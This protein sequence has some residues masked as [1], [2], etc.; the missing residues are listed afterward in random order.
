MSDAPPPPP[1][2][3]PPRRKFAFKTPT[4]PVDNPPASTPS[5][6]GPTDVREHFR[7]AEAIRVAAAKNP[8][9]SRENEVHGILRDNLARADAAGLNDVTPVEKRPNRR[10]RDYLI[11][12][13]AFN[14]PVITL[15]LIFRQSPVVWVCALAAFV[16]FNLRLAWILF[17]VGDKY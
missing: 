11:V 6:H 15:G 14:V 2:S 16:L 8:A 1:D 9:P 10:L 4:F 7:H 17:V 3:D 13:T 5:P 12:A